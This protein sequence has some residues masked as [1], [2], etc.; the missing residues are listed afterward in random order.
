MNLC[1]H[2]KKTKDNQYLCN[3]NLYC[4]NN[5][6]CTIVNSLPKCECPIGYYGLQCNFEEKNINDIVDEIIG[7]IFSEEDNPNKN[8]TVE[9]IDYYQVK[10]I[11]ML[12]TQHTE[13][14]L[15]H[16]EDRRITFLSKASKFIF[17]FIIFYS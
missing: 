13:A 11:S 7:N 4:K 9:P 14:V 2:P 3:N 12:I 6:T 10:T 15:N 16:I 17:Y 5:G 1:E 8:E